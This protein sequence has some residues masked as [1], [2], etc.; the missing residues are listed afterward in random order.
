MPA[1]LYYWRT[2]SG[3]EVDFIVY[4][5]DVFAAI[6][7]KRS[8]N[9]SSADLKALKAFKDDYPEACAYLLYMGHEKLLINGVL[10][11][12]CEEFLRNL[13]PDRAIEPV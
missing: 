13:H 3:T 1:S 5:Q 2:K 8:K 10:C 11:V 9:V 7:V 4:G 12:P 6:E